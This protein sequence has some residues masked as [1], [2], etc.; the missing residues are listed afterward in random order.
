MLGIIDELF[1]GNIQPCEHEGKLN[2]EI[3]AG[4]Q[5]VA[6]VQKQLEE[7]L[8]DEQKRLLHAYIDEREQL[9]VEANKNHFVNGFRMGMS[10]AIDGF[11]G[12]D[13]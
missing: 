13:L 5:R 4:F 9:A 10:M 12:R 7:C 2:P 1:Y 8:N 3:L 6:Q 11:I